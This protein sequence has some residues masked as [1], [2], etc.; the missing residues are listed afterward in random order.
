MKTARYAAVC[1]ALILAFSMA[2]CTKK[3]GNTGT[4][5]GSPA[6]SSTNRIETSS[7]TS[8]SRT[9]GSTE[10]ESGTERG[11]AGTERGTGGTERGTGGVINDL[12]DLGSD[13]GSDVERG[14]D[15]LGTAGRESETA[16]TTAR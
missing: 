1:M 9:G 16:G 11:N 2:G 5:S 6:E 3:N 12:E 7:G 13:I 8:E 10:R 15:N 4:S 14:L